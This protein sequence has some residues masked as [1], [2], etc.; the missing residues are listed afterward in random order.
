[1][2]SVNKTKITVDKTLQKTLGAIPGN[3][4]VYSYVPQ[5][6]VLR[7]ADVFLTHCG[8][9][10]VNEAMS[11]GVPMVAM[12]FINDQISNA[13]KIIELGIGKRVRSFPNSGRQLYETV[14]AVY[15]EKDMKNRSKAIQ[16]SMGK[17][18]SMSEVVSSIERLLK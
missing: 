10:S 15:A 13:K 16:D 2:K 4:Y 17:E 7:H 12:P 11:R 8:M 18:I 1:L 14:R 3:I 6:E 5:V 9:N